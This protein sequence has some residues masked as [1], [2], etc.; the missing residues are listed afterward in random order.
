M[1]IACSIYKDC[2]LTHSYKRVTLAS[3]YTH[4]YSTYTKTGFVYLG[5]RQ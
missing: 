1:R 3:S 5:F 4:T 2:G